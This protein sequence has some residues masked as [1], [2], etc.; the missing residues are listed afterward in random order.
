ML[1]PGIELR[2]FD[3][4]GQCFTIHL[5]QPGKSKEVNKLNLSLRLKFI[6]ECAG[7][8]SLYNSNNFLLLCI[9]G[10]SWFFVRVA[11]N[12]ATVPPARLVNF[13]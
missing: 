4:L 9:T 1:V 7:Y 13:S 2:N 3:L 6:S 11:G 10:G 5:L 8:Q 12:V